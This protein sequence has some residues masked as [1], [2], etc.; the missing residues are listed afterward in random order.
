MSSALAVRAPARS[1]AA[2]SSSGV[3]SDSSGLITAGYP[4]TGRGDRCSRARRRASGTGSTCPPG[5]GRGAWSRR[6][7]SPACRRTA[8]CPPRAN[9]ASVAST[10]ARAVPGRSAT[11]RVAIESTRSGS[12]HLENPTA[13][14]APT[15]RNNWLSGHLAVQLFKGIDRV[16]RSVSRGLQ[17]ADLKA[18]VL[19]NGQ[20]AELQSMLDARARPSPACGVGSGR[21]RSAPAPAR[22]GD[23]PPGRRRDEQDGA[24]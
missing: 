11:A 18:L 12:R 23:T 3:S 9:P 2:A 6:S 24:G 4:R 7:R 22:A 16:R 5:P 17:I 15:I 1:A 13:T 21:G 10:S 19:G 8:R 20:S 14:S